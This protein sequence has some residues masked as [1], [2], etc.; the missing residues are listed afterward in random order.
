MGITDGSEDTCVTFT[1]DS[2]LSKVIQKINFGGEM[3]QLEDIFL[4]FGTAGA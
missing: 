3:M 4:S 1:Y 2:S